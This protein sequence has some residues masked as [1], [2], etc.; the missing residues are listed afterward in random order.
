MVPDVTEDPAHMLL[1]PGD[2]APTERARRSQG[3]V[4]GTRRHPEWPL[5]ACHHAGL[6]HSSRPCLAE[7]PSAEW[8]DRSLPRHPPAG[9]PGAARYDSAPADFLPRALPSGKTG[10]IEFHL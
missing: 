10:W 2:S 9:G 8:F 6:L 3:R 7:G 1:L 5:S 4:T